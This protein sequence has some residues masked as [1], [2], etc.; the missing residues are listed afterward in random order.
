M[1]TAL[2]FTAGLSLF[3][4]LTLEGCASSLAQPFQAMKDGNAPITVYRLQNFEATPQTPTPTAG[5]IQLPPEIQ[6]WASAAMSLLPPGLLPP[7]LT[8][9]L[10]PP[11]AQPQAPRFHNFVILGQAPVM[12]K[13]MHD[14]LLDTLG[15]SSSFI[16]QHDPC[17]YAE[18][19]VSMAQP[20]GAP[21]D[22]L[23]V[24]L[25]CDQVAATNFQWPYP[26]TGIPSDTAKKLVEVF[27]KSFGG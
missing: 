25:S 26:V 4:L 7:G 20:N 19:G 1:R 24:S 22:D 8:Q 10:A 15:H 23:L 9:G 16:A 27:K 21:P 5:S 14:Q 11:A 2:V 6:Q 13:A 17:M 3:A 12:D 18:F